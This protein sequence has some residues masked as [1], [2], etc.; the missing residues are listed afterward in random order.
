[1]RICSKFSKLGFQNVVSWL[2]YLSK[3]FEVCI[4]VIEA[5]GE[6][7]KFSQVEAQFDMACSVFVSGCWGVLI[8]NLS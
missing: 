8:F 2:E 5:L 4:L 3:I 1:M 7:V 6:I